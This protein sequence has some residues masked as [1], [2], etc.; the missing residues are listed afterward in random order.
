MKKLLEDF[1]WNLFGQRPLVR[2]RSAP[3]SQKFQYLNGVGKNYPGDKA[4][5]TTPRLTGG[6]MLCKGEGLREAFQPFLLNRILLQP[7]QYNIPVTRVHSRIFIEHFSYRHTH[8]TR[9]YQ[10]CHK[11]TELKCHSVIDVIFTI[12]STY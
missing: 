5:L 2:K 7:T 12:K 11:K 8:I 6:V 9:L 3:T 4:V 1:S 10:T